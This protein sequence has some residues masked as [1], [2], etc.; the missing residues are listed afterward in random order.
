MT[1]SLR[2]TLLELYRHA[3]SQSFFD[4]AF[5]RARMRVLPLEELDRI[6]PKKGTIVEIGCGHGIISNYLALASNERRVVGIDIDPE[7]IAIA[8]GA[9]NGRKN[10]EYFLGEFRNYPLAG[11]EMVIL[12]G[13]LLLIPFP[14][15]K[16]LFEAIHAALKPGGSVLLHDVKKDDSAT[17]RLHKAKEW[18]LHV[19][20][21]TKGSGFFVMEPEALQGF[22]REARF[23]VADLGKS[24]D[25]PWHSCFSYL[26][27][28]DEP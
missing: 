17:F 10:I 11:A 6:V 27:K 12:F 26:L 20:G 2:K 24:L 13:V 4:R 9:A 16:G 28:K 3:D 5:I 18:L 1:D 23:S 25:V 19:T 15:W 14:L 22:L 7:R 21:I 8:R